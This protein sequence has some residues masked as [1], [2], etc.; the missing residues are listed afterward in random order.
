MRVCSVRACGAYADAVL[1]GAL[2]A[3]LTE[4]WTEDYLGL[5]DNV[6]IPLF[7]AVAISGGLRR[8]EALSPCTDFGTE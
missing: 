2:V 6:T 3:T 7:T 8:T 5:D 1:A 4:L